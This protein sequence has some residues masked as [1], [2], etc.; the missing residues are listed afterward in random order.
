[1]AKCVKKNKTKNERESRRLRA[2]EL[3]ENGWRQKYI[4]EAL[5][6]CADTICNWVRRYKER[7]KEGLKDRYSSGSPARLS[8]KQKE[9]LPKFLKRGAEYYG[10]QGNIWTQ[11]RIAEVIYRKFG[12]SYHYT[13]A[14]RIARS[15]GWSLQK[16]TRRAIQRD[17]EQIKEWK[18][19]KWPEIK[20]KPE[21]KKEL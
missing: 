14:G 9:R 18:E 12:V 7:G 5:G 21:K 2:M 19:K 6:V 17:E 13:H 16:P 3:Y 11:Q 10:F 20:K 4:A 8:K 15:Q 1:M